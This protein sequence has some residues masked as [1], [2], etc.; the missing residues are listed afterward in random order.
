MLVVSALLASLLVPTLAAKTPSPFDSITISAPDG[1]V[2]ASFIPYG[3]TLTNF[4][5]R[6]KYGR[7]RDVAVGYDDKSLYAGNATFGRQ[8]FGPIVGRYANRI[9]NGTFAIDGVEYHVPT[10]EH[11]GLN[12]LHGGNVGYDL[13]AWKLVSS[14]K[15]A[16]AFSLVDVDGTEGFPGTVKTTVT[17][18]LNAEGTFHMQIKATAED[19]KTPI[20]LSGHHFWNLEAF[21]ESQDLFGHWAQ[22]NASRVIEGDSILVPTGNLLDVSKDPYTSLDFRKARS[23]GTALSKATF[24]GAGCT[25]LDNAWIYDNNTGKSPAMSVWSANSGIRLDITTNQPAL[26]IYTCNGIFNAENPIPRKKAQGKGHYT[27]YSCFVL[28]QESWI[29]AIDDNTQS[30]GID[31]IYGP[32]TKNGKEYVWEATHKFST[33]K[34]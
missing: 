25:G 6:D 20:M 18:T 19:K 29:G 31:Q 15:N 26:Q 23:I 28:E 17:Y 30:W 24:C 22:F 14:K 21:E 34:Q 11:G 3:A 10:N 16:V 12:T 8:Y 27:N 9:K 1:S 5:A 33:F 4:W 7:L 2:K 13:R 32:G